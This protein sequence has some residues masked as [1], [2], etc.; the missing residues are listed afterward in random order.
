MQHLYCFIFKDEK[1]NWDRTFRILRLFDRSKI[2]N[3]NYMYISIFLKYKQ[4]LSRYIVVTIFAT[5]I[6]S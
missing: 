6:Y 3:K 2:S 5:K 4:K 1:K